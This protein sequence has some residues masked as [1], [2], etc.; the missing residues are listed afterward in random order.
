MEESAEPV[1]AGLAWLI[2]QQDAAS[3]CFGAPSGNFDRD[4]ATQSLAT[5]AL[6]AE[7]SGDPARRTAARRGLDWLARTLATGGTTRLADTGIVSSGLGSLALVEGGLLLN[8]ATLQQ[9]AEDCLA[10]LDSGMPM[11]PGAAGLSG[12]VLLALAPAQ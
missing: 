1:R 7:G 10:E 3:G 2:A 5:L 6:L 9:Q 8:D 11:Q 4:V 12:F